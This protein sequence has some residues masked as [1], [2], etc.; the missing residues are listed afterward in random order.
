[1]DWILL[2]KS[3][4]FGEKFFYSNWDNEFFLRDCLLLAH[5]EYV[6]RRASMQGCAFLGL[7]WYCS[8]YRASN[9]QKTNF[10][11]V[12][13]HFAAKCTK[14]LNFHITKTACSVDSNQILSDDKDRQ[15][16]LVPKCNPQIQDGGRPP[17]LKKKSKNCH[18]SSTVLTDFDE[19]W[20]GNA[21]GP[22]APVWVLKVYDF[23]NLIW[24]MFCEYF[25]LWWCTF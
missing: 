4:K 5:P 8:P 22:Y 13:R 17:S 6:I 16:L 14:Y 3:C 11:G 2:S 15:V 18:I 10:E 9:H 25:K 24:Q 19:I 21:F 23:E 7:H 1:M 12:N 20:R